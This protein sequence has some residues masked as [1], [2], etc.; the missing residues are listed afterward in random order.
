MESLNENVQSIG[1][2]PFKKKR[3]GEGK[4]PISK[5]ERI[6]KAVKTRILNIPE[7]VNSSAVFQLPDAEILKQL[8][9][10]FQD[11]M[12]SKSLKVTILTILPKSCSI[13]KVQE[14]FPSAANCMIRRASSLIWT[15]ALCLHIIPNQAKL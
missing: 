15:K 8:K 11:S 6:E 1:K 5:I 14:V 13:W 3:L 9:E 12:T 4:Y 10:K 7:N 2:S